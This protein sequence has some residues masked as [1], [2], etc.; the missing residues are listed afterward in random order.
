MIITRGDTY[1]SIEM[2]LG[3]AE[4]LADFLR[5]FYE[6]TEAVTDQLSAKLDTLLG[7]EQS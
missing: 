4:A 2:D 6:E 3:E 5:Q 7:I 1:V